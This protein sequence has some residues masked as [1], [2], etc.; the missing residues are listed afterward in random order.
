MVVL[1]FVIVFVLK[2]NCEKIPLVCDEFASYGGM[3]E[4]AYCSVSDLNVNIT[5]QVDSDVYPEYRED[6][7]V[8]KFYSCRLLYIPSGLFR[9][10]GKVRDLDASKSELIEIHRNSFENAHRLVY[11]TL[12]GNN[13][14]ELGASI[15]MDAPTLFV[16]DF[17]NNLIDKIDQFAFADAHSLSRVNLSQNRIEHLAVGMFKDQKYLDQI[18]LDNNK[19]TEIDPKLFAV[20]EQLTQVNL[21]NNNLLRLEAIV[22]NHLKKMEMFDVSGNSLNE[23]NVS[24]LPS[25][26][27]LRLNRNN[28]TELQLE[29][30]ENVEAGHNQIRRVQIVPATAIK[31]LRMPHNRLES[32]ANITNLSTL[33]ALDL[34]YNRIGHLN[35]TT[36]GKLIN[37]VQLNLAGTNLG[38]LDFGTFSALKQLRSLDLSDNQLGQLDCDIFSP[39]MHQLESLNVDGNNLTEL[40]GSLHISAVFPAMTTLS[41]SK[42]RFNC[43]YLALLVR[44]LT[45]YKIFIPQ[46]AAESEMETTHVA[47]IFCHNVNGTVETVPLVV[48][49]IADKR[50]KPHRMANDKMSLVY[51]LLSESEDRADISASHEKLLKSNLLA[52]EALLAIICVVVGVVSIVKVMKYIEKIGARNNMYRSTTTM[53]TL[54]SN[55]EQA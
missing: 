3:E 53:N 38:R 49:Q 12:A 2:I 32:I 39:Y 25:L 37:L 45:M 14:T 13:I 8:L 35:I 50:R 5:T 18:Y 24:G 48:E 23:I 46:V 31:E 11:L 47:G 43:T 19:L 4:T 36:L 10:F 26:K 54:Q 27:T 7:L 16:V 29:N 1:Y 51:G 15:F 28:L 20:N 33:V 42:N 41:I 17:S 52:T 40:G 55:L 34:S 22:F 44:T 9:H 6:V 30:V 21:A